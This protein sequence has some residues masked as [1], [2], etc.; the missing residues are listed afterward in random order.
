[1]GNHNSVIAVEQERHHLEESNQKANELI[2]EAYEEHLKYYRLMKN[3]SGE[4]DSYI[5]FLDSAYVEFTI[6]RD[7]NFFD[8]SVTMEL[9]EGI[10]KMLKE[11]EVRKNSGK[12]SSK[13]ILDCIEKITEFNEEIEQKMKDHAFIG[14]AVTGGAAL[15][16]TVAGIVA[17]GVTM[18]IFGAVLLGALCGGLVFGGTAAAVQQYKKNDL[19]KL[20]DVMHK[21]SSKMKDLVKD[22]LDFQDSF[23]SMSLGI[24]NY[25]DLVEKC[26]RYSSQK[27]EDSSVDS[28]R[29]QIMA[30]DMLKKT[31]ELKTSFE[32]VRDQAKEKES[33]LQKVV[34]RHNPRDLL[35]DS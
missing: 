18:G 6:A 32:K 15:G 34:F 10:D 21:L 19:I 8:K 14:H 2:E 13:G 24:N 27:D 3:V 22:S 29:I 26:I 17:T 33:E 4:C 31:E 12:D 23:D 25:I 7:N 1:M 16:M 20:Q 5:A 11:V 28:N 30:N 9:K 35:N